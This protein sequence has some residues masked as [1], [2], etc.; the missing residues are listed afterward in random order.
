MAWKKKSTWGSFGRSK[1]F[2]LG[3]Y[4]GNEKHDFG[5][6]FKPKRRRRKSLKR[7]INEV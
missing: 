2:N 4:L 6:S 5:L 1:K 3:S 7:W